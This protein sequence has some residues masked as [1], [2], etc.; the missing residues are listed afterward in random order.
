MVLVF[1]N[2]DD[3]HPT[4]VIDILRGRG[5][6]VF[7]LNSEALLTDYH[8]YWWSEKS[9]CGFRLTNIHSGLTLDSKDLTAV[10]D[11]RPEYP[12][13][14]PFECN[15]TVDSFNLDEAKGFLRFFRGFI[16]HVPSIGSIAYD[17]MAESKML[18]LA[19]AQKV[20]FLSPATCFSNRKEDMLT[21]ASHFD[22]LAVKSIRA[23]DVSIGDGTR[24]VF[25]TQK[26]DVATLKSMPREAF[27]QTAC[28]VQEY[29]PKA[30]ELRETVVCDNVYACRI[31]TQQLDDE[32][33]KV[34]CRQGYDR[35]IKY[36]QYTL[37]KE[38]EQKC[39]TY[40][41]EMHINYGAFDFAVTPEGEYYF[42]E[43]NPNG[44]WL[45][46]EMETGLPIS[47]AI[48]DA[49]QYPEIIAND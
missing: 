47:T 40:L 37:P 2:K 23:E 16:S 6:P 25:F 9:G 11:R 45:W 12:R 31:D 44:Q 1:T 21:F 30:Y 49:L 35:G 36:S 26:V 5:I 14:L 7:R 33:G 4:P 13:E 18:Q 43:C 20:G 41:K 10:L 32:S 15:E 48:A 22:K 34:D 29:L 19:V 24:F 3:V 8:F 39:V 28:F 38:I 42:L 27:M 46:I 17:G